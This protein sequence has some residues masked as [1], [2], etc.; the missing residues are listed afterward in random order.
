MAIDT[1]FLK[2]LEEDIKAYTKE[3]QDEIRKVIDK[4]TGQMLTEVRASSPVRQN[5]DYLR[6]HKYAPGSYK[7]G[8]RTAVLRD[9]GTRYLKATV[10]SSTQKQLVHLLDQGHRIVTRNAERKVKGR[11]E[12][13]EAVKKAQEK[14]TNLMHEDIKK[15][16]DK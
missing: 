9:D 6:Q 13:T 14:Y 8:W 7:K 3:K 16:L 4:R 5:T 12:G 11:V 10:N 1:E 15:I 2:T